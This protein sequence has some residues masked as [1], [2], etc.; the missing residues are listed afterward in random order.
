MIYYVD[1]DN[2]ICKTQDSDYKNSVP[3]INRIEHLNTLYQQGNE[4]HYWT[5]RGGSTGK[6]WSEF[7]REQFVKWG[8]LYTSLN[9]RKPS[10]DFWIDDKGLSDKEF[11]NDIDN[12]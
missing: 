12:R 3:Y 9:F 8:I 5:A 11:F 10:Y 7:T 6:D 4:V 1:I 2:T